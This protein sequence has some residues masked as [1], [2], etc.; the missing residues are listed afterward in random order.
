MPEAGNR[1]FKPVIKGRQTEKQGMG[2][3]MG[4]GIVVLMVVAAVCGLARAK[5]GDDVP[6]VFG[7]AKSVY[8]EAEAGDYAKPGLSAADRHAIES[9]Q[10][11]LRTWNRY[12]LAPH[13][14]QADLVFVVRKGG[15][16][17]GNDQGGLHNAAA[18]GAET[19]SHTGPPGAGAD[20]IGS[21]MQQGAEPDR[22]RVYTVSGDGKL[23]GP[24]WTREI[25]NGLDAPGVVIVQQ[26]KIA[27]ERVYPAA[28]P[29]GKPAS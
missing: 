12:T 11:A 5:K 22:L 21:V 29:A 2:M 27:V 17:I 1:V 18:G 28:A 10:D 4:R 6:A 24:V 26:M 19:T 8:V 9:V 16:A 13:R 7:A 15:P 20:N 14:E 23:K 3:K 25:T